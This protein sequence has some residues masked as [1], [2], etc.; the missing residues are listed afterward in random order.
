MF[1]K[2]SGSKGTFQ[3]CVPYWYIVVAVLLVMPSCLFVAGAEAQSRNWRAGIGC[4]HLNPND[5]PANITA[6]EL[7]RLC[8][9]HLPPAPPPPMVPPN[10]PQSLPDPYAQQTNPFAQPFNQAARPSFDCVAYG[11]TPL[12]S[13]VRIPQTEVLCLDIAAAGADRLMGDTYSAKM[14]PQNGPGRERLRSE[15]KQW[16]MWRNSHCTASWTDLRSVVRIREIGTCL[17]EITRRRTET[18]SLLP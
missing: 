3:F 18:L 16:L 11:R 12:S 7:E 2:L 14:R 15:Q 9:S 10:P 17:I 1:V 13:P 8:F 6:E 5:I 4:A